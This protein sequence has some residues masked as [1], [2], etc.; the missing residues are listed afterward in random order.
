M[1]RLAQASFDPHSMNQ[2]QI[3]A[4][5]MIAVARRSS[6]FRVGRCC[7]SFDRC[8]TTSGPLWHHLFAR[9][10]F[11]VTRTSVRRCFFAFAGF[12]AALWLSC[13]LVRSIVFDRWFAARW[14]WVNRKP[15]SGCLI[16]R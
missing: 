2:Q 9:N 16:D 12:V 1:A 14:V 4:S 13:C 3:G 10:R 6:L 15:V 5:R 7:W 8:W 11:P